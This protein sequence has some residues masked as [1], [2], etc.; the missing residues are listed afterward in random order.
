MQCWTCSNP[1]P[2]ILEGNNII[3]FPNTNT[4][5][6]NTNDG[7][8]DG[9]DMASDDFVFQINSSPF[10][11][12]ILVGASA[13]RMDPFLVLTEQCRMDQ[14]A[15]TVEAVKDDD[16]DLDLG[17]TIRFRVPAGAPFFIVIEGYQ[18]AGTEDCGETDVTFQ[19]ETTL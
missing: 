1:V 15:D 14:T 4:C 9:K 12:D 6:S 5:G 3:E 17:S 10:V 8:A 2:V 11:R 7:A 19:V 18:G 16:A 13:E